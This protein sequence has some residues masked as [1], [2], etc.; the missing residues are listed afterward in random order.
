MGDGIQLNQATASEDRRVATFLVDLGAV[1]A[2]G[3]A[4]GIA[5]LGKLVAG[6]KLLFAAAVFLAY[7]WPLEAILGRTLGKMLLRTRVTMRNGSALD[8]A[9]VLGR[10]LA[11]LIPLEPLS[12]LSSSGRMWHDSLSGTVV[13]AEGRLSLRRK[14]VVG[15]AM[16]AALTAVG[17]CHV[18][19]SRQA[20]TSPLEKAVRADPQ[21][22][23]RLEGA[24]RA[25]PRSAQN[26]SL[27]ELVRADERGDFQDVKAVLRDSPVIL[28]AAV[29]EMMTGSAQL[30][31][32]RDVLRG[33]MLAY[34]KGDTKELER[35][36]AIHP[37]AMP[38][39]L[40]WLV[41]KDP[42]MVNVATADGKTPLF[43][44]AWTGDVE[45][46]RFLLRKGADPNRATQDG[47]TPLHAAVNQGYARVADV[48]L[49]CGA[50]PNV[51]CPLAGTPLHMAVAAGHLDV[52]RVLMQH[53]AQPNPEYQDGWSLLHAAAFHGN[54]EAV[55]L[56]VEAGADVNCKDK[57]G[58]T[59]LNAALLGGK[60]DVATYLR[61]KGAKTY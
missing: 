53:N 1:Y 52:A 39:V 17:L 20:Q 46:V 34:A 25:N 15:V 13:V 58:V 48:L 9:A 33:L 54:I 55:K 50:D 41:E 32:H 49:A 45:S 8:P 31:P 7:Y 26:L 16:S 21:A 51:R 24:A 27:E 35:L 61:S 60:A 11:R 38:A 18:A 12:V 6:N 4:L 22:A 10:T 47:W 23:A 36:R 29:D 19:A 14:V 57:R 28:D 3:M 30:A 56:I 37:E 44:V 40:A 59:P 43:G 42:N 2:I 5:G